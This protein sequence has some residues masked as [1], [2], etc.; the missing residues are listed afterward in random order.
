MV[1]EMHEYKRNGIIVYI[2]CLLNFLRAKHTF[3]TLLEDRTL[4][5]QE[6]DGHNN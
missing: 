6:E 3:I 2:G 4:D 5:V 1:E